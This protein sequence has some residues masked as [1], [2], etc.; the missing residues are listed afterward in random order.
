MP[1][2]RKPNRRESVAARPADPASTD[3]PNA[4]S[5]VLPP[6]R[7]RRWVSG[8]VRVLGVPVRT[9]CDPVARACYPAIER[10]WQERYRKYWPTRFARRML[11]LDFAL[12]T[13]VAGLIVA[14]GFTYYILPLF[15]IVS[16]VR[17]DVLEPAVIKS[18]EASD[19]IISYSNDS[20]D[21]I[22]CVKLRVHLPD[23]ARLVAAKPPQAVS[24]DTSCL[25]PSGGAGMVS[26]DSSGRVVEFELGNL[27]ANARG[28][29]A[30]EAVV[31]APTG[32]ERSVGAELLYWTTGATAPTRVNY[33]RRWSVEAGAL[34][35]SATLPTALIRGR[36]ISVTYDFRNVSSEALGPITL[37]LD[38]PDDFVLTGS[39][40]PRASCAAADSSACAA[41]E[42]DDLAPGEPG[43]LTLRGYF[44]DSPRA[45]DAPILTLSAIVA[46]DGREYVLESLRRN[47]DPQA[48]GFSLDLET[49]D[50]E[51][52][53]LVPGQPTSVSVR[54][55]ND[56]SETIR[57]VR[58][59][60]NTDE[61][62][63]AATDESALAWNQVT[64]PE[65]AEVAPGTSGAVTAEFI[66][67]R[68]LPADLLANGAP[69]LPLSASATFTAGP[70]YTDEDLVRSETAV[71]NVPLASTLNIEA[72][73][74][75]YTKDG[76]QLGIG[77]LP[78]RVGEATKYR[79]LLQVTNSAGA[80]RDAVLE[81][82]LPP[83]VDWTGNYSVSNGEAIDWLPTGRRIHWKIGDLTAFAGSTGEYLGAS[84]EVS[85]TPTAHMVGT[86]ALLL[87][88]IAI[89]GYD[90]ATGLKL[91]VAA[92]PITTDLPYDV[93]AAGKG[94][95]E[96]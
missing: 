39:S 47:L 69:R 36:A 89:D 77:P 87:S 2:V 18:G 10:H 37:R 16:N 9:V 43:Q 96:N 54:Y 91:H 4:P 25:L 42:V 17:V 58:L 73:A 1:T 38:R 40:L 35:L 59:A 80:V 72:A 51:T 34:E 60:L 93:R 27:P 28:M 22:G 41:W 63:V 11:I 92:E 32:S 95:I 71:I 7:I 53:G 30:L 64:V 8:T 90:E 85:L 74:L 81:A 88:D 56:G 78:P 75:Y 29:A 48:I 94:L 84:F 57:N 50:L 70:V 15:P 3:A 86:T 23:G 24:A 12:L 20:D 6:N 61:R 5:P 49:G 45:N 66:V 68:D 76:D 82:T 13:L 26:D 46:A 33:A 52:R 31:Y 65:L 55:S 19:F 62:L 44:A 67:R 79:V 21:R 83:S 14:A